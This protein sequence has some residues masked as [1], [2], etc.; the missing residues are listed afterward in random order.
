MWPGFDSRTRRHMW[1]E[2]VLVLDPSPRVQCGPGSIPG[3]GVICGL[4]L[5]WFSTLLRGFFSECSWLCSWLCS[6]VMHGPYSGCQKAPIYVFGP[7]LSS[8]V[9]AVYSY[10]YWNSVNWKYT[11]QP[12]NAYDAPREL[13]R[14]PLGQNGPTKNRNSPHPSLP[15]QPMDK[16]SQIS[17]KMVVYFT[18]WNRPFLKAK[19]ELLNLQSIK[20]NVREI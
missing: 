16:G 15:V 20:Y 4:S 2:F 18:H 9:L 8:C 5:C 1:T 7:T 10:S 11:F 13:L 19:I 3:P 6:K 14:S 12:Q 17:P